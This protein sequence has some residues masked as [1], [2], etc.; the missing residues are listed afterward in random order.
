MTIDKFFEELEKSKG[1]FFIMGN[2]NIRTKYKIKPWISY[3]CRECNL[4]M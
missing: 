3:K 1:Q 4:L 2:R